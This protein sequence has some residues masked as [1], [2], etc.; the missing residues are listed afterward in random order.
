M[1]RL[2][3]DIMFCH[4]LFIKWVEAFDGLSLLLMKPG[5]VGLASL[6]PGCRRIV[7]QRQEL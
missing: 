4:G 3:G 7:A 2:T 6:S 5:M 1:R